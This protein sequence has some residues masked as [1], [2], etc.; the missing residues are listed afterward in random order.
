MKLHVCV[1]LLANMLEALGHAVVL[2][3]PH[4]LSLRSAKTEA[5]KAI[6]ASLRSAV[7]S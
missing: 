2:R 4:A 6:L 5:A 3:R 7:R 1:F